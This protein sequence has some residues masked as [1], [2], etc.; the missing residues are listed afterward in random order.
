[1]KKLDRFAFAMFR[2]AAIIGWS[3]LSIIAAG[4]HAAYRLL[5]VMAG[6]TRAAVV[7]YRDH[8]N[9]LDD[10]FLGKGVDKPAAPAEK[11]ALVMRFV[12]DADDDPDAVTKFA[13]A[14]IRE[15]AAGR[16]VVLADAETRMWVHG[17]VA[18]E[19]REPVYENSDHA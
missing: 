3:V 9:E 10:I 4:A 8:V 11:G 14:A 19:P 7:A 18:D 6:L 13:H 17:W 1:M 15:L 5:E 12:A 2:A 16:T